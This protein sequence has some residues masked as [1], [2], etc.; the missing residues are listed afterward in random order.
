MSNEVATTIL[1]QLGGNKFI[2][3]TGA[4]NFA[5]T[6][7]GLVFKIGRNAGKCTHVRIT[8]TPMDTYLMEF[9]YVSIK[10]MKTLGQ[11]TDVYCDKLQEL[12]TEFTGMYTR[13]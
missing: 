13:L 3:M 5:S 7:N 2:V 8:L 9:L 1:D 6:N 11:Y 4:K 10:G 12:F